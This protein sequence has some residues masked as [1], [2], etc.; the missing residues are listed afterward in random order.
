M[1]KNTSR[2]ISLRYL[3]ILLFVVLIITVNFATIRFYSDSFESLAYNNI[4]QTQV[5]SLRSLLELVDTKLQNQMNIT[6]SLSKNKRIREIILDKPSSLL[7]QINNDSDIKEIFLDYSGSLE[8]I[9]SINIFSKNYLEPH[10]TMMAGDYTNEAVPYAINDYRVFE[11]YVFDEDLY[12]YRNRVYFNLFHNIG[13]TEAMLM[14]LN[15][16]NNSDGEQIGVLTL[17]VPH[18]FAFTSLDNL[19]R[20]SVSDFHVIDRE[21]KVIYSTNEEDSLELVDD[22][23]LLNELTSKAK[24]DKIHSW[25]HN[26]NIISYS[27]F[28]HIDW[29]LFETT[30]KS[31][32]FDTYEK[33]KNRIILISSILSISVVI[34]V[35]VFSSFMLKGL[36]ELLNN[37]K[38]VKSG[39]LEIATNP[40][41]ISEVDELNTDFVDMTNRISQLMEDITEANKKERE[42]ELMALQA[43]INPHFLYNTLDALYWMSDDETMSDIINTLGKFFRLSLSKGMDMVP[44]ENELSQV[45][46]YIKIQSKIYSGRFD[47]DEQIDPKIYN[48]QVLKLILQPMVENA[49][50]HGFKNM[51]QGGHIQLRVKVEADIIIEIEDNGQG[52]DLV[53]V[54]RILSG[55]DKTSGYGM[56][57]VDERIRLKFGE[58][59]GI[60]YQVSDLEGAIVTI[61]LPKIPIRE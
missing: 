11:N 34:L 29:I 40:S 28:E 57:N 50:L 20:R 56:R 24:E 53:R 52:L 17:L 33:E 30:P 36:R 23:K 47:Y 61:K 32:L 6:I 49:I 21:G 2:K 19:D 14:T 46:N 60:S 39:K 38:E 45:R 12:D 7:T 25:E 55:Y 3:L 37:I 13:L 43:Q 22:K 35:I 48:Y 51:I 5:A 58:E 8:Y 4:V 27:Q 41:I 9:Y 1:K 15:W 42:A 10:N 16:I 59:Y 44:A 26:N 18:D 31:V 54:E